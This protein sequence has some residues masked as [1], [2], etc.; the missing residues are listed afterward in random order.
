MAERRH[1]AISHNIFLTR[2]DQAGEDSR[3]ARLGGGAFLVLRAADALVQVE[4]PHELRLAYEMMRAAG[5]LIVDA[6]AGERGAEAALL[7]AIL[8]ALE[9]PDA[10]LSDALYV[11][12]LRYARFLAAESD[13]DEAADVLDTLVRAGA[14]DDPVER[15]HLELKIADVRAE[16][17]GDA[18]AAIARAERLARRFGQRELVW[19]C[20]LAEI[21]QLRESE[22]YVAGRRRALQ[23]A[24][25]L[26]RARR[27]PSLR[28][29][30]AF[31]ARVEI[32]LAWLDEERRKFEP[33]LE[34]AVRALEAWGDRDVAVTAW[35]KVGWLLTLLGDVETAEQAYLEVLRRARANEAPEGATCSALLGLV[36]GAM[37]RGDRAAFERRRAEIEARTAALPRGL[38]GEVWFQLA[39]AHEA[40]GERVEAAEL[41]QRALTFVRERDEEL[42]ELIAEFQ[43]DPAGMV[44]EPVEPT[45]RTRRLARRVR[46]LL[47]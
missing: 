40:F 7:N 34:H 1:R 4:R 29:D 11:A 21:Q 46:R 12:L 23:L 47:D 9:D 24:A 43:A 28:S 14:G 32:E 30:P 10:L 27:R 13:P 20:R 8:K 26:R 19:E 37:L 2:A 33:A 17:G 6:D 42:E 44:P 31:I 36:R 18:A 25:E 5:E 45:A 16:L 41:A 38:E 15:V 3:H 39:Q 35:V 22:R